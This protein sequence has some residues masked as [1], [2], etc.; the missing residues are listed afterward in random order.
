MLQFF[1]HK[2]KYYSGKGR[3]MMVT[4]S[5]VIFQ[6]PYPA[7]VGKYLQAASTINK[8]ICINLQSA[9]SVFWVAY[10]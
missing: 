9:V 8:K 1:I 4:F 6:I 2:L 5:F 3:G 7:R 10:F